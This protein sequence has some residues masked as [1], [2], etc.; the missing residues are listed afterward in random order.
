MGF[1]LYRGRLFLHFSSALGRRGRVSRGIHPAGVATVD[2][3]RQDSVPPRPISS[4]ADDNIDTP[5]PKHE[6]RPRWW[7]PLHARHRPGA[8]PPPDERRT[9][10]VTAW[11]L[12][13][14]VID[15]ADSWRRPLTYDSALPSLVFVSSRC[16]CEPV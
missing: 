3:S 2:S 12:R 9:V 16:L 10:N 7:R 13:V 5:S 14:R 1:D 4:P 6:T 8:G 15:D 11:A